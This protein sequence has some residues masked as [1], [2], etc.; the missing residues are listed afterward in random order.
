M[1][2]AS[3][4][5]Y[6]YEPRDAEQLLAQRLLPQRP[7]GNFVKNSR[8][9]GVS[10]RLTGQHDDV[11]L[12][13]YGRGGIVEGTVELKN[14]DSVL[15]VDVKI[16]GAIRLK[17][18]AEGGTNTSS[19][20]LDIKTLWSRD[21]SDGP[22]PWSLSFALTLPLTFSDGKTTY[23]L[24][25]TFEAHLSGVPGFTANIDYDVSATVTRRRVNLFGLANTTVTTPF[26]FRPR[27]H[28]A[29]PLPGSLTTNFTHPSTIYNEDWALHQTV[30]KTKSPRGDNINVKLYLPGSHVYCMTDSI[31][32][33]LFITSS[34]FSLASYLPYA[35]VAS[36]AFSTSTDPNNSAG[37]GSSGL[38]VTRIQ[39]LRQ[40]SVDVRSITKRTTPVRGNNTDIW[41]TV[42]IGEGVFRRY[43]AEAGRSE[44]SL[45]GG[46]DWVAWYS[47]IRVDQNVKVAGFKASGLHVKDFIVLSM[48]PPDP[49]KSPFSDTRLVIPI[50]LTTDPWSPDAFGPDVGDAAYSDPGDPALYEHEAPELTY[51]G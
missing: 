43:G 26:N 28:P 36:R 27:S 17:E 9:G 37:L 20:C 29:L 35:P 41:K 33:H 12:P 48:N 21:S 39:I 32:S 5:S 24:P 25:P 51:D 19:L 45:G 1:S 34:A 18:V 13:E 6:H 3:L 14:V 10:L 8:S 46:Q 49:S 2:T 7:Q 47:E 38:D 44:A 22:C 11:D 4:P 40:T 30:I 23:P 31:P 15:S 42:Q 50:K 16:E